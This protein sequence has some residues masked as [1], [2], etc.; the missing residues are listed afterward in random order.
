MTLFKEGLVD[1]VSTDYIAGYWDPIPLIME[2][3]IEAGLITL[4]EAVQ[5]MSRNVVES[6]PR[7]GSDRGTIAPGKVADLAIVQSK[8]IS[9]VHTVIIGGRQVV[10]EGR[11]C[12]N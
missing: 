12:I 1:M 9:E 5:K 4:P 7:I 2:K 10:R 6:I 11:G 3:G 8:K